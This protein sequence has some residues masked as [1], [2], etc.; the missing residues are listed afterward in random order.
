MKLTRMP[1]YFFHLI[2]DIPAQDFLG[3]DCESDDEAR[4]H[5]SFLAHRIGTEKPEMVKSQNYIQVVDQQNTEVG[6]APL[7][8]VDA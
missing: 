7:A 2:G 5:A 6:R 3:H 8:S 1:H 4:D